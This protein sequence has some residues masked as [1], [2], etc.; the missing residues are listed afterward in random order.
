V[1]SRVGALGVSLLTLMFLAGPLLVLYLYVHSNV[2]FEIPS[3]YGLSMMPLGM[4]IA[5]AALVRRPAR[6][7]VGAFAV[8]HAAQ[9]AALLAMHA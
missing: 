7:V 9:L 3:R 6:I 5:A 4:A 8:V 2:Y 1:S